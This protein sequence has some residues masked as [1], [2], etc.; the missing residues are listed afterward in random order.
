MFE[1]VPSHRAQHIASKR[2]EARPRPLHAAVSVATN[3]DRAARLGHRF[4]TAGA[5]SPGAP[6][7][8][9]LSLEGGEEQNELHQRNITDLNR[10]LQGSGATVQLGYAGRVRFAKRPKRFGMRH[11]GYRLVQSLIDHR[12]PVRLGY[13]EGEDDAKQ[14]SDDPDAAMFRKQ[15]SGSRIALSAG[16]TAQSVVHRAGNLEVEDTPR[17]LILA[18]ELIHAHRA[19]HGRREAGGRVD[20]PVR[21]RVAGQPL[22]A[23]YGSR[24]EEA[25]TV[26]L[27]G[28]G[29][30]G[31][32]TE[33]EI[34]AAHG[35]DQRAVYESE[36]DTF[37]AWAK[38]RS[39]P[40][41]VRKAMTLEDLGG[42]NKKDKSSKTLS[43]L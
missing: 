39:Q 43:W 21:G 3:A 12:H 11:A 24:R 18:H 8:R 37:L 25:E 7:Q 4:S 16:A 35:V 28:S 6:V 5:S 42:K 32:I 36:V 38:H 30:R 31:L 29:H 1:R 26:G 13:Q 33:N 40:Q 17:H 41:P 34:R 14:R 15:G 10:I 23:L 19:A 9:T 22:D 2:A 20:Y 27:V